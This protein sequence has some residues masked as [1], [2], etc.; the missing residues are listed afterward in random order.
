MALALLVLVLVGERAQAQPCTWWPHS[1]GREFCV[2]DPGL[3]WQDAREMAL[4]EGAVLATIRTKDEEEFI[5]NVLL[6]LT[7]HPTSDVWIGLTNQWSPIEEWS[8]ESGEPVTYDGWAQGQPALPGTRRH[9]ALVHSAQGGWRTE[10][11]STALPA[12]IQRWRSPAARGRW[13]YNARTTHWYTLTPAM[14]WTEAEHEARRLGGHLVEVDDLQEHLWIV[15]TIQAIGTGGTTAG[16]DLWIG[17]TDEAQ[18]NVWRWSGSGRI[19]QF[20]RWQPGEPNNANGGESYV[21]MNRWATPQGDWNDN[22]GTVRFNGLVEVEDPCRHLELPRAPFAGSPLAYST[23]SGSM[24][25]NLHCAGFES[26]PSPQGIGGFVPSDPRFP[27]Y[28][29]LLRQTLIGVPGLELD[30]MS[31]GLDQLPTD[32]NGIIRN[33]GGGSWAGLV[34]SVSDPEPG[35]QEE[36][37]YRPFETLSC[38]DDGESGAGKSDIYA[39]LYDSSG[40]DDDSKGRTVLVRDSTQLAGPPSGSPSFDVDAMDLHL[41][42][43]YTTLGRT[44]R[45]FFEP[46]SFYFS[47]STSTSHLIPSSWMSDPLQ[48]RSGATIFVVTRSPSAGWGQPVVFESPIDLGLLTGEDVDALAIDEA[49]NAMVFSTSTPDRNEFLYRNIGTDLIGH[50]VL[51]VEGD[52]TGRPVSDLVGLLGTGTVDAICGSDPTFGPNYLSIRRSMYASLPCVPPYELLPGFGRR[53]LE[54]G[55]FYTCPGY[56]CPGASGEVLR[57]FAWGEPDVGFPFLVILIPDP[58]NLN[59]QVPP[60]VPP[61]YNARPVPPV[62]LGNPMDAC[63]R[64][65]PEHFGSGIPVDFQWFIFDD[66]GT[67]PEWTRSFPTRFFL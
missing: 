12:L 33:L 14:T 47:V 55:A 43:A 61:I 58:M 20:T 30:A 46:R 54:A 13:M 39:F 35:G 41:A 6:P 22:D 16:I 15:D 17:L 25:I 29:D 10:D 38:Q 34:F 5:R 57:V 45:E 67:G 65:L 21:H 26:D 1:S 24:E 8:W 51:R 9:A 40:W 59:C 48:E 44:G 18:P 56:P 3:T 62:P 11:G 19:A 60:F 66:P 28:G 37:A 4:R 52:R 42:A 27:D 32:Q 50:V 64:V 31:L 63:I 7:P 49:R 53:A 2:L 23:R 36:R